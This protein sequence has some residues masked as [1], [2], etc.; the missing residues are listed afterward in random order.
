MRLSLL[1]CCLCIGLAACGRP[2]DRPSPTANTSQEEAAPQPSAAAEILTDEQ[3]KAQLSAA[4]ERSPFARMTP[5]E[6]ERFERS[7]LEQA[8]RFAAK[9]RPGAQDTTARGKSN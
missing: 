3:V 4:E 9:G 5:A 6:R 1:A 2:S 7:M 8:A